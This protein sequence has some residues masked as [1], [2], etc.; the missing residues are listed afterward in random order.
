M[1]ATNVNNHFIICVLNKNIPKIL[2]FLRSKDILFS[3]KWFWILKK[4]KFIKYLIKS[5]YTFLIK[6]LNI[7]IVFM[8]SM[9]MS[10][11]KFYHNK[12]KLWKKLLLRFHII[13]CTFNIHL[14]SLFHSSYQS[15]NLFWR[16]EH[17]FYLSFK[18]YSSKE[19]NDT[20]FYFIFKLRRKLKF[21]RVKSC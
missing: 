13:I 6:Y 19:L 20:S 16:I 18:N 17:F 2:Q 21:F 4:E 9:K 3:I 11:L 1:N 8:F 7:K 15:S 14:M 10:C 12:Y 5:K